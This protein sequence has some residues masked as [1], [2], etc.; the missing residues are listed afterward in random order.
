MTPGHE[1]QE[2]LWFQLGRGKG[3]GK[4]GGSAFQLDLFRLA[5]S[6]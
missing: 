5:Q 1:V 4:L 2:P 3:E 6:L